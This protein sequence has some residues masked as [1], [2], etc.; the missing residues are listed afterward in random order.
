MS[1]NTNIPFWKSIFTTQLF[2][3]RMSGTAA[4]VKG[5]FSTYPL[6]NCKRQS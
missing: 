1:N 4:M 6:L 3:V 5:D 2:S